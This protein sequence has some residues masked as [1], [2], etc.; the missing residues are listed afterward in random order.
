M[1]G[2]GVGSVRVGMIMMV[3]AIVIMVMMIVNGGFDDPVEI[4]SEGLASAG[5]F[6]MMV[7]A[8]L[9]GSNFGLEA[10]DLRAVFAHLAVHGD[11][12][13]EDLID[14]LFECCN[15]LWMVIEIGRLDE[16]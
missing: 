6:D 2:M 14:A 11:V 7:M 13:G 5:A 1:I 8:L 10:Q 12:A 4:E 15:H 16:L 3:I 9:R